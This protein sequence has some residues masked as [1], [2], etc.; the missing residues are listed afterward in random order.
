MSGWC[1]IASTTEENDSPGANR[2]ALGGAC[3]GLVDGLEL[4]VEGVLGRLMLK[5]AAMMGKGKR[6]V[7]T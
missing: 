2:A 3:A 6:R 1:G 7:I 4:D 5:A